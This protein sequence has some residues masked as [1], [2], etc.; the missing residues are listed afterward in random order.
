MS[1]PKQRE[2]RPYTFFKMTESTCP[3]CLELVRTKVVFQDGKAYFDKFCPQHGASRALV[4]EDADF[5][6]R[7]YAY[8]R[9]GSIPLKFSTELKHG[10]PSDCG[11]CPEHQQ[12]TCLPI[13]EIT[14]YCNLDCPVCIVDNRYSS[15]MSANDFSDI[16]DRLVEYEGTLEAVTLSG[17]EPTIHPEFFRLVELGRR[18]EIGR[19]SVVTNGLRIAAERGFCRQLKE[20][21]VYVIL[22]FDGFDED[23]H[24]KVRGRPLGEIKQQ[25]LAHLA[26]F[27]ISTQISFVPVKGINDHELGKAVALL[28]EREHV[29]SLMIQ[30]FAATGHGGGEFPLDPLDRLTIPGVIQKIEEQTG[31]LLTRADFMPLP[32]SHPHCVS[33]TYMLRLDDGSY[34][35]FSRFIDMERHLDLFQQTATLEPTESTE[36]ALQDTIADIYSASG[37]IPDCEK[38]RKALK[39][40]LLEMYSSQPTSRQERLR[41]AER[42]AKTIFLHHYMDRHNFDLERIMK[43]CH[44][45]PLIDG[46]IMPA[47]AYNMFHRG[48]A[49]GTRTPPVGRSSV[50]V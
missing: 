16:I 37:E 18:P 6:R 7:S 28:L 48:A 34:L 40:A 14:D 50:E 19:V 42:Q 20:N 33:L 29:L 1:Q 44:H 39:R 22:Q 11:L 35:P 46:R 5:Y 17:G 47:C 25:A 30:P 27:E 12:H 31:G 45:Y 26:E 36:L 10:C 4:S 15:H 21:N 49:C 23:S 2:Y 3:E 32:C 13:I 8:A 43:C 41:I 24:I 38:V 9:P